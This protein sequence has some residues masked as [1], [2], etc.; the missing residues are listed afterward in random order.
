MRCCV[1]SLSRRRI[2]GRGRSTRG[3]AIRSR[4]SAKETPVDVSI[5]V[6]IYNEEENIQALYEKVTRALEASGLAYELILVDD[7][8]SDRS[9]LLL[10]DIAGKDSRVKVIRFRR[11]FGQTAAMAAGFDA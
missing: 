1:T 9:F 7:G 4:R 6:P 5:V 11:N 2:R 10:H 8:S 3:K